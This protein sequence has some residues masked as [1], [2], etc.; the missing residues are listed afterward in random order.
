MDNSL[1][2]K[3]LSILVF[4]FASVVGENSNN[5]GRT[6]NTN[7]GTNDI[8]Y[9]FNLK[10]INVAQAKAKMQ[11]VLKNNASKILSPIQQ[12]GIGI[13]KVRQLFG[14]SITTVQDF[15][16]TIDV[17]SGNSIYNFVITN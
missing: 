1:L 10:K 2:I 11:T 4:A 5:G 6:W 13:A 8:V 14:N 16:D 9:V 17:I 7:N 3:Y 12:G 15:I